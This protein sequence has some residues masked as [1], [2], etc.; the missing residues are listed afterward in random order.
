MASY[1]GKPRKDKETLA[2]PQKAFGVVSPEA[3]R[4]WN[5]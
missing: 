4:L 5:Q 2:A 3:W 1:G